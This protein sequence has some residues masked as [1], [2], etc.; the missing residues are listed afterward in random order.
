MKVGV[1]T[2]HSANN[3]GATLQTWALQKVL[4]DY[5]L[6]AGV[7]HYHPDVIDGLYDPM[8]GA[9]GLK[10][11]LK[12]FKISLKTPESLTRYNKFQNFLTKNFNLIGDYKTYEELC[13][14]DL[15]LDAYIVGSDQVWNPEHIGGFNPAYYLNFAEKGKKKL[16]YAASIGGDYIQPKYK[17]DMSNALSTFT[18]ISVR[19]SSILEA[20]QELA[21]EPVKLVL[22]PTML[23]VKEDY[24]EIKV[25]SPIKQPYILVYMIE[26][27]TQVMSLANSMSIS[28]GLPIIQRRPMKG[29]INELP[30]FY[31]ADAGEFIGLI[32]GA[33]LVITNSFHGTVF[34]ILYEKPF[35]SML[36]SDTGSRTVD[37][38]TGLGLESHILYDIADFKEFSMFKIADPKELRNRIDALKKSSSEFL[39]KSL[40]LSDRYD[41]VQCPTG[42][43][44]EKC[45]G[46]NAC[47]DI[48]KFGAIRMEAD[49]EG[50]LYPIVDEDKCTDCGMCKKVCIRK[51]TK[52]I[53][54]EKLF[55]KAYCAH[56][57]D[58]DVRKKSSSGG[59]FPILAKYVIEEKQGVVVGVRYDDNMK[60]VTDIA[61]SMDEAK[62]F[63]GSKYV[64]SDFQGIFPKIKH[65]LKEERYVLYS[66]LPCECAGLRSYLRKDY[67]NLLICEL[68]CHSAP[69]PKVFEK[70]VNYLGN[71]N[72]SKV[73]SIRFRGKDRGW[74][75]SDCDVIVEFKNGKKKVERTADN[76]YYRTFV[77]SNMSRPSCS[78]CKYTFQNRVGDFTIGDCWGIQKVAPAMND[79]KG[80]NLVLLNNQKA[81]EVFQMINSQM[82]LKQSNLKDVF[83]KNHKKPTKDKRQ[84][85]AFF[86]ELD[87]VP[88]EKLLAKYSVK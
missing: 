72:K 62:A 78:N 16:S 34:S 36:H 70:Y 58:S 19:E 13:M 25:K 15:D 77:G 63:S 71:E 18:G 51:H 9:H 66:G 48:C 75:P 2:F 69:S 11:Q 4:K 21:K 80:I 68:V 26:K 17:E 38:L 44:K 12:K 41:Q 22:D 8:E 10:R 40:S 64:K 49:Q 37:L 27:N 42:I 87:E 39:I 45:Y 56:N 52:I 86:S 60:A 54:P 81:E 53:V 57:L 5:G 65:L 29:M 1:M 82:K 83:Y 76:A 74:K 23:L 88:I 84:R 3:Y 14:S 32:E 31:T 24:E 46:C 7:I 79:N 50:F 20:V 55:P 6:D 59:V 30:P 73:V 47:A 61:Q 33:E 43:S 35:V 85:I 67:N 28:L